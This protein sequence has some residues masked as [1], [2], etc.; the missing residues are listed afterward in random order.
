MKKGMV[1]KLIIILGG[2]HIQGIQQIRDLHS[3][4]V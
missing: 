2:S 4:V 3:L 1:G